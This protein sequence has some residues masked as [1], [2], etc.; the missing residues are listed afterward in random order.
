M[1]YCSVRS[2][3]TTLSSSSTSPRAYINSLENR[4]LQLEKIISGLVHEQHRL[5][6]Q[7]QGLGASPV[8]WPTDEAGAA[9]AA[10]AAAATGAAH[11]GGAGAASSAAGGGGAAAPMSYMGQGDVAGLSALANVSDEDLLAMTAP[12]GGPHTGSLTTH[13]LVLTIMQQYPMG[14]V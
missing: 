8:T 2:S 7:L 5:V 3:L 10:A 13:P 11:A 12:K 6:T 9:A 4:I 14:S 1:W